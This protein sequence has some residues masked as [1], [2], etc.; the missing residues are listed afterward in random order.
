MKNFKYA[1]LIASV[2][3]VG[4]GSC[5]S[6]DESGVV[7]NSITKSVY[8][9]ISGDPTTYAEGASIAN[10]STVGFSSGEL[11]FVNG[12]GAILDHYTIS[13]AESANKNINLTTLTGTGVNLSNLPGGISDV[14]IVGNV[15][16]GITLPTTGNISAVKATILGVATQSNIT[17]VNLYGTD[18]LTN[19]SENKYTA[20]VS[21]KP[22]VARIELVN[23]KAGGVITSFQVDGIFIDN[24]YAQGKVDGNIGTITS[25][26]TTPSSFIDGS[27][28]YPVSLNPSI[29]DWYA[30]GLPTNSL[31][32]APATG[33]WGYNLFATE[34]GSDVPRI[35]I[36]LSNILTNDGSTITSPQFVTV[37]GLKEGS[38]SLTKIVAGKVYSIAAN[39][40]VVNESVITPKPNQSTIEVGVKVTLATWTVVDI[41]PEI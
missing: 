17:K 5:S 10:G 14:H 6:N 11:F 33:V 26:G 7:D 12:S 19:T 20:V 4:F 40:L 24:Y 41:T 30:S 32:A 2:I 8:L 31:V 39:T 23:I 27:T 37:K 29:Y 25:N 15:P 3:I 21:L 9:K 1:I 36:R 34:A 38:T 16:T 35:I 18:K 22:T 13:S 28:E